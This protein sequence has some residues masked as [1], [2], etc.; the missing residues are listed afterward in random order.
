M[1]KILILSILCCIGRVVSAQYADYITALPIANEG[2]Y[3]IAKL[4]DAGRDSKEVPTSNCLKGINFEQHSA[5]LRCKIKAAG[6]IA[7]DIIPERGA[8]DL[9]FIVYRLP[10]GSFERKEEMR[11]MAAG[12]NIGDPNSSAA[13]K[14]TTGLGF[15][16]EDRRENQGCSQQKDNFLS[17]IDAAIGEEYAIVVNNFSST[18][19]FTIVFKGS[20]QLEESDNNKRFISLPMPNPATDLT[21]LRI[22]LP[23]A[24]G[25]SFDVFNVAGQLMQHSEKQL[26][27]GLHEV[28]FA[29][30]DFAAGSYQI[31]IKGNGFSE[32]RTLIKL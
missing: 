30:S 21:M 29:T 25:L 10:K 32:T 31:L 2:Q 5:W 9:D 28:P 7:F 8:D 17:P 4:P 20:A 14:G 11:C 22:S 18:A 15:F 26:S 13:C 1:K 24:E 16:S 3:T 27:K 19:G 12:E 6:T 23:T